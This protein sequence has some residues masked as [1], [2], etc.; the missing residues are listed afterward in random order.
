MTKQHSI[1]E[2][3]AYAEWP[4]YWGGA[5][6]QGLSLPFPDLFQQCFTVIQNVENG[7]VWGS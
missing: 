5:N 6:T 1:N 4:Q 2:L 7:V 3:K